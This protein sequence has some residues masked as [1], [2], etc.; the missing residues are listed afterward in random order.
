MSIARSLLLAAAASDTLNGVATRSRVVRRATR[1]FMPGESP[2]AALEAGATLASDGRILLF[3]RLGEALDDLAEAESVRDHYL[4]FLDALA[5]RGLPGEISI[6]PTQLGIERSESRCL[7]HALA[8]ASHAES[9]DSTLWID[10][11]DASWVDATLALYEAVKGAHPRTGLALQSY[12]HRTPDDLERLAPL[13]PVIRLVKG[14]YAEPPE[15]AFPEKADTDRAYVSL[16]LQMLEGVQADRARNGA[17]AVTRAVFG[18]H[19]LALLQ[20][21]DARARE[22]GMS[23]EDWE[24]H[25][26]YGIRS[27]AQTRLQGEGFQVGTL[28]SYGTAWYRWY[29]RRLAER[30]ANVWFV[31]RSIFG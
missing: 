5:E 7:D 11:E 14:A 4:R 15:V 8:L 24:V 28:I 3:T 30:P 13:R 23:R 26:L 17:S 18:T 21:I 9:L 2:E 31:A 16:A 10:M 1:A 20:R 22:G 12:L 25:M 6:K 29:M 19:D 27:S